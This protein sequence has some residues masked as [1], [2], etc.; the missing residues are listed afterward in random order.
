MNGDHEKIYNRL[1]DQQDTIN[2]IEV[3]VGKIAT[4]IEN[5]KKNVKDITDRQDETLNNLDNRINSNERKIW[6]GAGGSIVLL[7]VLGAYLTF[8]G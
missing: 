2:N 3:T 7:T 1:K 5:L 4:N 6:L 8:F